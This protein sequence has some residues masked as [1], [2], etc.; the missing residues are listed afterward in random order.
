MS[1][2]G[3]AQGKE[4]LILELHEVRIIDFGQFTLKS[5]LI[6]PYYLDLRLLVT[7]PYLLELVS[8]V[9]WEQIRLIPF[10][11]IVGVPYA[12][13]PI[14]TALSLRH[15]KPIIMV[16]KERKDY[17]KGKMIEGVFHDGQHVIL[18]DDVISDGA[19]KL[20]TIKPIEEQHLVVKDVVVLV[21]RGQGGPATLE[22]KGYRCRSITTMEEILEVLHRYNRITFD[23]YMQ[24]RKFMYESY[25][26]QP[27]VS[28]KQKT[29]GK[30]ASK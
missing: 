25:Q 11:L 21:D 4:R 5:G 22:A 13:L 18:I 9:I 7:F 23:Q 17:G 8:D 10:D 24:S 3:N 29:V 27:S 26:L 28:S 2:T 30:R 19:S 15:N 20:E 14:A 1:L 6:S 16:R 12:A